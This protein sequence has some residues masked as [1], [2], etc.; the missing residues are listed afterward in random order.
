MSA[1]LDTKLV[2]VAVIDADADAGTQVSLH[3]SKAGAID[4]AISY[5]PEAEPGTIASIRAVLD[6]NGGPF[7]GA[8]IKEMEVLGS[9]CVRDVV[10]AEWNEAI[11]HEEILSMDATAGCA[12]DCLN[13]IAMADVLI[14]VLRDCEAEH[15]N[16]VREAAVRQC[17]VFYFG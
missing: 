8:S 17:E 6:G 1:N 14:G 10:S 9:K 12:V 3:A 7:C 2:W 13:I 4:E 5:F 15:I 11:G 16:A